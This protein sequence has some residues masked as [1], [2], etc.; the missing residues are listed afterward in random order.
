MGGTGNASH[1]NASVNA[2]G[3]GFRILGPTLV[4]VGYVHDIYQMA[5]ANDPYRSLMQASFGTLGALGGGSLG[6]IGGTAI[7]PGPGT[8]GG[9]LVGGAAGGAAGRAAGG[10]FYDWMRN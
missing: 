8:V 6:A 5:T 2:L 9:A 10:E 4:G 7:F 1:S 3:A